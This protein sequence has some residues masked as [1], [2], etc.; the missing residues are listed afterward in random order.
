MIS[1]Q[2]G[3]KI[4]LSKEAAGLKMLHI[5]LGWD[6]RK[7]AGVFGNSQFDLDASCLCLRG[8]KLLNKDD[9]VY[10]GRLRH[11]SGAIEHQGDN[12]NG[13]GEGDDEVILIDLNR[14]PSDIDKI[15]VV[16]TIYK[17]HKRNQHF[18]LVDNAFMRMVDDKSRNEIARYNLSDNY[19][20]MTAM[21]FGEVYRHEDEW[22]VAAIGQGVNV[23][24]LT[25][26]LKMY[27]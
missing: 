7:P 15:I 8:G 26:L 27:M 17:A 2:K 10:Y 1:L 19:D 5:G 13:D 9:V 21:I 11:N 16:V 3:Q 25:D 24:G 14:V 12:L 6:S 20:N 23:D 18:G 4:S 22:K